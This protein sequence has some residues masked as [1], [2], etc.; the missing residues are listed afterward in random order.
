MQ[1]GDTVIDT[2]GRSWIIYDFITYQL[3]DLICVT[4]SETQ[5]KN[6]LI[7]HDDV[8]VWLEKPANVEYMFLRRRS[9]NLEPLT[10]F[11]W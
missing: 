5:T 9:K 11:L 2:Q 8:D 1:V 7:K 4:D 3:R 6:E 10:D